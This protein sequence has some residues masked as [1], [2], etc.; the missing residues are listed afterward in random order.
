MTSV[1][2]VHQTALN[3]DQ[4]TKFW[5]G[6]PLLEQKVVEAENKWPN[7]KT[8]INMQQGTN[9]L[10]S[11]QITPLILTE[12]QSYLEKAYGTFEDLRDPVNFSKAFT[13][14][15]QT[16][17]RGRPYERM[18]TAMLIAM[19]DTENQRCDMALPAL[20]AA[21]FLDARWQPFMFGSDAPLIY[22]LM[23]RCLNQTNNQ[24]QDLTRAKD[25]LVLSIRLQ[26]LVDPLLNQINKYAKT[27]TKTAAMQVALSLLEVGIPSALLAATA[28]SDLDGIIS[29]TISQSIQF[30]PQV[31]E[32]DEAPYD[33]FIRP[34]LKQIDYKSTDQKTTANALFQIEVAL[35]EIWKDLLADSKFN[36]EISNLLHKVHSLAEQIENVAKKPV[37]TIYLSGHGPRLKREGEYN[38]I[39]RI[40]PNLPSDGRAGV[41][42]MYK[43][44]TVKCGVTNY[45]GNLIFTLCSNKTDTK[46]F[47]YNS[48]LKL[49]SSS[50][51]A[52]TTAGRKFDRILKG[53]AQFRMGSEVAALVGAYTAFA[54]L[55][56]GLK[57]R[58]S[59]LQTA[60]LVVGAFAGAA[61]VAGRAS[62]PEADVRQVSGNFEGGYLLL[63]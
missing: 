60:A 5:R 34:L 43:H 18:L 26:M 3:D 55:D 58:S 25:G 57:T 39:A 42:I 23:I 28:A 51:Q 48:G 33:T 30:L 22:A 38:E 36:N 41:G 9:L 11:N 13:T 1:S 7:D 6:E 44:F 16:P 53:R 35:K 61:W 49:W 8:L 14:D 19:I 20:K 10:R 21:E 4:L 37:M 24:S 29:Q 17:Y 63:P 15:S 47:T 2:C 56:A 31:L 45:Q 52:M 40:V 12:A 59:E 32:Q 46:S 27:S 50:Y 54:L 62:N